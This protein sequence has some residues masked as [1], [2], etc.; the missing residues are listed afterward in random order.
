MSGVRNQH[1][2]T[3]VMPK[4]RAFSTS[5]LVKLSLKLYERE[6]VFRYRLE[7]KSWYDFDFRKQGEDC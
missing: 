5:R 7:F 1:D 2:V 3:N 6:A 4:V